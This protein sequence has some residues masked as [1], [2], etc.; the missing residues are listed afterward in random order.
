MATTLNSVDAA[1]VTHQLE[2]F[3]HLSNAPRLSGPVVLDDDSASCLLGA[4]PACWL[5]AIHEYDTLQSLHTV[6]SFRHRQGSQTVSVHDLIDIRVHVLIQEKM[7]TCQTS[8]A[9][10]S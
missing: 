3:Q 10:T 6:L 9:L 4:I 2:D 1:G 8:A 5:Y 7:E